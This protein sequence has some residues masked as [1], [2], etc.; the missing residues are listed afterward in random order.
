[1]SLVVNGEVKGR[2]VRFFIAVRA[3]GH[4]RDVQATIWQIAGIRWVDDGGADVP[5]VVAPSI[6]ES[7]RKLL[8]SN[9]VGYWDA[10][11]S[12]YIDL[13]WALYWIDRPVPP[14][15]PRKVRDV[16]HGSTAQV[17]HA[18]LL[19]PDRPW[20]VTELAE[21]AHVSPSTVHQ[22]F[23]FLEDQLWMEK[24]GKGP[25]TVRFLREP[26]ALLD[27]WA[28]EHSL[29]EYVP[30]RFHRWA[31]RPE[32]LLDSVSDALMELESDHALTLGFGARFVAPYGT[33]F[34]TLCILVPAGIDLDAVAATAGLQ[35]VATGESV[36]F[37]ETRGRS[38]LLFR[39]QIDGIWVASD[40]Q[41]YLD[42]SA[43]PQRGKEQARHL[44]T[45]R[46]G[47]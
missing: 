26:G 38:P 39:R 30:H 19:E 31:Q 41:L 35:P 44:R 22:V 27:A 28:H 7:S 1:V 12:L 8:R 5:I 46:L 21:R 23:T 4:P 11:G 9:G 32:Q 17:L 15:P 47:Y 40:I 20:H 37:L 36:T 3:A 25:R 33:G 45:E 16:Y 14:A 24:E 29:A 43:W 13:P 10:G 34:D 6:S 18:V 42:L 2:P